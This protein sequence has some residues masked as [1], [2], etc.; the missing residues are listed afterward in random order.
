VERWAYDQKT[1]SEFAPVP[2]SGVSW[3]DADGERI[4]L[5]VAFGAH[6]EWLKSLED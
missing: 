1:W 6:Q 2:E 5:I 4:G 3:I